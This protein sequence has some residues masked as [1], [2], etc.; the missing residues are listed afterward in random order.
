V[1]LGC[2]D[3]RGPF[4]SPADSCQ[5]ADTDARG[6]NLLVRP[7]RRLP[8][9]GP[10]HQLAGPVGPG[11]LFAAR[12]D[13]D[14]PHGPPATRQTAHG[15]DGAGLEQVDGAVRPADRQQ[16]P[17]GGQGE[18]DLARPTLGL[19]LDRDPTG[20]PR[21]GW[22][23]GHPR[24]RPAAAA[25]RVPWHRGRHPTGPRARLRCR[26]PVPGTGPHRPPGRSTNGT[27]H[28]VRRLPDS[29]DPLTTPSLALREV[30]CRLLPSD[31][32]IRRPCRPGRSSCGGSGRER[33][34]CCTR[35]SSTWSS[36]DAPTHTRATRTGRARR[37]AP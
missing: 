6:S 29:Q 25:Q 27:N 1:P 17:V 24:L 20:L 19:E 36:S 21:P 9:H 14:V 8:R 26:R 32:A 4:T 28:A 15:R 35:A 5:S 11:D 10:D 23:P 30:R 7:R 3:G 2:R 13:G 34:C 31:P 18:L 22:R 16:L 37:R 12:R 33:S